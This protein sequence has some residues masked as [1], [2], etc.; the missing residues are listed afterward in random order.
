MIS[1]SPHEISFGSNFLRCDQT[2]F[3]KTFEPVKAFNGAPIRA[4]T[5]NRAV[6]RTSISGGVFFS[7]IACL[8]QHR[9][10]ENDADRNPIRR[11]T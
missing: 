10:T 3:R 9:S 6:S 5:C 11:D 1:G 2:T 8:G 4:N 7:G